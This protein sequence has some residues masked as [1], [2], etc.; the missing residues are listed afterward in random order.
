MP[1]YK[2]T[3]PETGE[4]KIIVGDSP[5][6][7]EDV[8]DIFAQTKGLAFIKQKG[9]LEKAPELNL[10]Q[11]VEDED[12]KN[13]IPEEKKKFVERIIKHPQFQSLPFEQKKEFMLK[14]DEDF[15]KLPGLEQNKFLQ[16]IDMISK[17]PPEKIM[18]NIPPLTPEQELAAPTL[19]PEQEAQARED[20]LRFIWPGAEKAKEDILRGIT[21]ALEMVG[22]TL[23][24]SFGPGGTALGYAAGG[25]AGRGLETLTGVSEPETPIESGLATVRD[26]GVGLLPTAA[27]K[28]MGIPGA[29]K[30]AVTRPLTV[31]GKVKD[32]FKRVGGELEPSLAGRSAIAGVKEQY[33]KV[34]KQ[35]NKLYEDVKKMIPKGSTANL[36]NLYSAVDETLRDET[37]SLPERKLANTILEKISPEVRSGSRRLGLS[38]EQQLRIMER[39]EETGQ[40]GIVT[41]PSSIEGAYAMRST[42]NEN[43][44]K[45]GRL[46]WRAGKLLDALHQDLNE[47]VEKLEIP[48]VT[49][50]YRRAI[51]FW[52]DEVIPH[53]ETV[54]LLEKKSLERIPD[55]LKVDVK[56]IQ[57]LK[58]SMGEENFQD[59]K[60]GF[61]TDVSNRAE[62]SPF[63][64]RNELRK[65]MATKKE[66]MRNIFDE[67]ELNAIKAA[68]DPGRFKK[69]LEDHPNAR[70]IARYVGYAT[71][72][73]LIYRGITRGMH[74]LVP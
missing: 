74:H 59:L 70:W 27:E 51:N 36:N 64:T 72:G 53:R 47:A 55:L 62:G 48:E 3:D 54:S 17:I 40:L 56:T 73:A 13:L 7:Q 50:G 12:F 58:G 60:R 8:A 6:T 44:A 61:L 39:A 4:S 37:A 32:V 22:A 68:S 38:P 16:K 29:V 24:S 57:K 28:A 25:R 63:K 15:K 41:K 67:E 42:L 45:G 52:R 71:A 30:E 14:A 5:P 34:S 23:G 49:Q 69:Y 33:Q 9:E 21:P 43:A 11:I 26:I 2:V 10:Q 66:A 18:S 31:R 19:T 1:R 35:G 20:A 65:L 46:G